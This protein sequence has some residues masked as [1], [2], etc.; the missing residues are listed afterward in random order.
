[1]NGTILGAWSDAI[2]AFLTAQQGSGVARTSIYTRRQHLNHIAARVPYGPWELT[3][4]DLAGFM[5]SHNWERET[6]RSRQTTFRAF[7]GWAAKTGRIETDPTEALDKVKPGDPNPRPVP[8]R[9]YLAALAQ[10]D[11]E[12]ALWIDLAA[13]HGLRRA[14]IACIHSDDIVE[15]LLG[16]DLI[17]HG[18]GSKLREVPLTAAMARK[19]LDIVTELGRGYLFRGDEDGHV[20]ARWLGT[21]VSRLL[22]GDW[23][24]HK[25]R[26]RAATRFWIASEGDPYVVADLMGWASLAMVRVYVKLPDERKRRIVNAASR[27]P[28]LV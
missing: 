26:H 4:D 27:V 23:T 2:T 9:V 24:I 18:K 20:S 10:A 3:T 28:S 21:R 5:A 15:T 7:Y 8:D 6:R 16:H 14:E 12:E 13:E 1:M 22:E 17:V 19:L 25:L 11:E